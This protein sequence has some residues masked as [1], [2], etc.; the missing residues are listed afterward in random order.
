[1]DS[2]SKT[3]IISIDYLKA[4]IEDIDKIKNKNFSKAIF[5]S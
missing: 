4:N 3:K 5:F 1:M 2:D